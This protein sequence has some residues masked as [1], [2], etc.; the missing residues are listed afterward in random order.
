MLRPRYAPP[1]RKKLAGPLLEYIY[2]EITEASASVLAEKN[3]TLIQ[4]RWSDIHNSP[5]IAPSLHTGEKSYFV[6]SVDT[7]TDKKTPTYCAS[8]AIEASE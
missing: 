8:L 7:G 1:T 4:D 2:D 3:V 6:S 5:I